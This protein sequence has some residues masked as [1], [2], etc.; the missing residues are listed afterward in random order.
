[1][2][3]KYAFKLGLVSSGLSLFLLLI[4]SLLDILNTNINLV[5]EIT[6]ASTVCKAAKRTQ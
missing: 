6:H 2:N 5:L 1:M 3:V 4:A